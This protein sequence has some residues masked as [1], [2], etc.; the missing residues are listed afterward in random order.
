MTRAVSTPHAPA[1]IGPYSQG[2]IA[3]G[4]SIFT[5]G[6]IGLDPE[7]KEMVPGG[8]AAETERCLE[9]LSAV[10][11]AAGATLA[12][13]VKTTVYLADMADFAAMNAVYERHFTE[14]PP[15]RSTVGVAAL[16][17]GARVEIEAVAM[18]GRRAGSSGPHWTT[19]LK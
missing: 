3:S 5:S 13:V 2:I 11:D 4:E 1:A 7:S 19:A 17:R 16:P 18:R 8:I 6:Q 12:D 10:L 14:R 15:A 9:N